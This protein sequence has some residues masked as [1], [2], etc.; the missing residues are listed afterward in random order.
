[1]QCITP[2]LALILIALSFS[3]CRSEVE[4][5]TTPAAQQAT[6]QVTQQTKS[7]IP[8]QQTSNDYHRVPMGEPA[9]LFDLINQ[10]NQ[11]ITMES[12]K[13]KAVLLT[14]IYTHCPDICPATL[15]KFQIIASQLNPKEREQLAIV[16]ITL[17]PERDSAEHL[18]EYGRFFSGG[19]KGWYFLTGERSK[20]EQIWQAYEIQYTTAPNGNIIHPSM[21]VL[22]DKQGIEQIDYHGVATPTDIIVTDLKQILAE[23]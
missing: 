15:N 20:L 7:L 13:G 5:E 8:T 23:K 16:S 12:L 9:P 11:P 22:I 1:M 18:R 21:V 3:G 17:D 10:D 2:L 4:P 14:F 19:D 6:G